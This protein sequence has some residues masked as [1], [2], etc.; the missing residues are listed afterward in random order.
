MKT[1]VTVMGTIHCIFYSW[2]LLVGAVLCQSMLMGLFH[3][4]SYKEIMLGELNSKFSRLLCTV[5]LLVRIVLSSRDVLRQGKSL[6]PGLKK[7]KKKGSGTT[8]CFTTTSLLL[9]YTR[10]NHFS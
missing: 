7:K 8:L 4:D 6:F 2:S 1:N 10:L 3:I 5:A 9:L